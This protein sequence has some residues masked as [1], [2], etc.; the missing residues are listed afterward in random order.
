MV[1]NSSSLAISENPKYFN[2]DK[3]IEGAEKKT[4]IGGK[5]LIPIGLTYLCMIE[6]Q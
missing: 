4:G 6:Q 2:A 3:L 1:K 5:N